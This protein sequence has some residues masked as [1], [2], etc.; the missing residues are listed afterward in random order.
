MVGSRRGRRGGWRHLVIGDA[1]FIIIVMI[2]V[3]RIVM[4][5]GLVICLVHRQIGKQARIHCKLLRRHSGLRAKLVA[6]RLETLAPRLEVHTRELGLGRVR[7]EE[8]QTLA[9]A[10]EGTTSRCK[11]NDRLLL[12]L[13]GR[14][15]ELL[16]IGRNLR[17]ALNRAVAGNDLFLELLVP[18]TTI[19]QILEEILIHEDLLASESATSLEITRERL[20][21]LIVAENLARGGRRHRCH[22]KAIAHSMLL[23]LHTECIPIQNILSLRDWRNIP[24]IRLEKSLA[25]RRALKTLLGTNPLRESKAG[26]HG[27]KLNVL[28][29]ELVETSRLSTVPRH[30][31]HCKDVGKTLHTESNRTMAKITRA[32][33][34][35]RLIVNIND[36]IKIASRYLCDFTEAIKVKGLCSRVHESREADGC[37]ITDSRLLFVAVLNNLRA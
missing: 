32:C 2:I 7:H 8:I 25:C 3:I 14:A 29:D 37:K 4:V 10:D 16:K 31:E 11:I 28:K 20:K 33:L 13:L 27:C 15:V 23:H 36:T 22:E 19:H 12:D 26:L 18:E 35:C 9:L 21:A 30:L 1:I 24:K 17:N 6:A 34:R 5:L